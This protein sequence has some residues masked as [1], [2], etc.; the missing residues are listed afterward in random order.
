MAKTAWHRSLR[1]I[2]SVDPDGTLV[3]ECGHRKPGGP[4]RWG[5]RTSCR[6]CVPEVP[7]AN[8]PPMKKM[9]DWDGSW[10]KALR[11]GVANIVTPR[12]LA[13]D[14]RVAN[15]CVARVDAKGRVVGYTTLAEVQEALLRRRSIE[16]DV[17]E[18]IR[19][20]EY[21]CELCGAT[22]PSPAC[23]PIPK[24]CA[25]CRSPR[26]ADCYI[27]LPNAGYLRSTTKNKR[28]A[29]CFLKLHTRPLLRCTACGDELSRSASANWYNRDPSVARCRSC[30]DSARR[31]P[32]V[33]C[34]QCGK[35]LGKNTR[36]RAKREGAVA[37]RCLECRW[38]SKVRPPCSKCGRELP[39]QAC[40]PSGRV[41]IKDPSICPA[42][43]K[44][45]PEVFCECGVKLSPLVM[46]PSIVRQRK[47]RPPRCSPCARRH[48][49]ERRRARL[50][51]IK[52]RMTPEENAAR[53]QRAALTRREKRGSMKSD[54]AT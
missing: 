22:T 43:R 47:G 6:E 19:P 5:V 26:C 14:P 3:L 15:R 27:E 13:Q 36:G 41:K 46:A 8:W 29:E 7:P 21:L 39:R 38:T 44:E 51:E 4:V 48:A 28:C 33:C 37:T 12:L 9:D 45:R 31:P 24:L 53:A 17:V 1:R 11:L 40:T 16:V 10:S 42:C 30:A 20:P 23:G 50:A 35:L 34:T 32:A 49:A 54:G 18:G 2:L 52:A 25:A